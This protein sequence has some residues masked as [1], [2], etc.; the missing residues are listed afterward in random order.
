MPTARTIKATIKRSRKLERGYAGKIVPPQRR[1]KKTIADKEMVEKV[2]GGVT[3]VVL[4]KRLRRAVKEAVQKRKPL[5]NAQVKTR[6][7]E[8]LDFGPMF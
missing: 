5:L 3:N 6:W 1:A 2:L 7:V 8:D 4:R